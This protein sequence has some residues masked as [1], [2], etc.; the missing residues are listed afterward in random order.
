MRRKEYCY[1]AELNDG[2][3]LYIGYVFNKYH[4]FATDTK[5][6]YNYSIY[7]GYKNIG[8]AANRLLQSANSYKSNE[9]KYWYMTKEK[10]EKYG[11]FAFT[12]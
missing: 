4:V 12:I 7:G 1:K 11:A 2:Y 9:V 10:L 8:V 5:H 3:I 6:S